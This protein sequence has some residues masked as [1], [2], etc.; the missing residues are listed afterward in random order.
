[1]E[2]HQAKKKTTQLTT[3]T[4]FRL[5][6]VLTYYTKSTKNK[7]RENW[8][9]FVKNRKKSSKFRFSDSL[10]LF[11]DIFYSKFYS[12]KFPQLLKNQKIFTHSIDRP[13]DNFPDIYDDFSC[14]KI[15]KSKKLFAWFFSLTYFPPALL[16]RLYS[17]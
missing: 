6:W 4:F 15:S 2:T 14:T 3:H 10:A 7:S 11:L 5:L 1:M 17:R 8:R 13:M 12:W 16:I 9:K